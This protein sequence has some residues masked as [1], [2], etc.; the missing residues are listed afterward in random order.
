MTPEND[1]LRVLLAL[2]M[3]FVTLEQLKQASSALAGEKSLT[4]ALVEKRYLKASALEAIDGIISSKTADYG[5]TP[6]Q[7]LGSIQVDEDTVR[8]LLGLPLE[9]RIQE[10]LLEWKPALDRQ[11]DSTV[12]AVFADQPTSTILGIDH[13]KP[14]E[15]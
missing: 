8:I 7:I 3:S 5:E 14:T 2:R 11:F 6:D 10:T 1:L 15:A 4:D 12:K 9:P 13:F